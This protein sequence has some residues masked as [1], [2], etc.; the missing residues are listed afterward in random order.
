MLKVTK[1]HEV[2]VVSKETIVEEFEAKCDL[3]HKTEIKEGDMIVDGNCVP[4]FGLIFLAR[5]GYFSPHD[6]LTNEFLACFDC[7]ERTI[8]ER[9]K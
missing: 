2:E 4:D 7:L 8:D 1:S 5:Y 3:C 9:D 6:G